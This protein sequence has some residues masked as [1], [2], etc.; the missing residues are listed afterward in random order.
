MSEVVDGVRLV[1]ISDDPEQRE[2]AFR[3]LRQ[4][5]LRA[6]IDVDVL[7]SDGG[8]PPGARGGFAPLMLEAMCAAPLHVAC[9]EVLGR[10]HERHRGHA[11]VE[12][13]TPSGERINLAALPEG[14]RVSRIAQLLTKK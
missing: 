11:E 5:L 8:A 12:L 7:P 14:D 2:I 1:V 10:F 4:E 9:A 13:V 6:D 3:D